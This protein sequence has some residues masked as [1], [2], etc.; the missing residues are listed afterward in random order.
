MFTSSSATEILIYHLNALT[1]QELMQ[2]YVLRKIL[3]TVPKLLTRF[4]IITV[5]LYY[6][7]I[8]RMDKI[9]NCGLTMLKL[10]T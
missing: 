7:P 9:Y 5:K 4:L 10:N 3:D 8:L 6:V 1:Q 2:H